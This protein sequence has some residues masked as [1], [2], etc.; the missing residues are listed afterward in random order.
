MGVSLTSFSNAT[1]M[2]AADVLGNVTTIRNWINGGSTGTDYIAVTS[3][4]MFRKLDVRP[5]GG[6]KVLKSMG[7]SGGYWGLYYNSDL[8]SRVAM[9]PDAHG[10]TAYSTVPQFGIRFN[11]PDDGYLDI[12]CSWWAWAIQSDQTVPETLNQ[13][14]FAVFLNS[15]IQYDTQRTL[16]DSA[17]DT[18]AFQGGQY[19]YAA[20]NFS[21]SART[22][23]NAGWN[24][25]RMTFNFA[26][27]ALASK[28]SYPLVWIGAR[29]MVVTY[30]RK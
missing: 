4:K 9:H 14:D 6:G 8:N 25:A 21:V 13:G 15:T 19:L 12:D 30:D 10:M 17:H 24:T 20:Q 7:P 23:V 27:R 28:A 11:C 29:S 16:Y 18:T 3:G 5:H 1:P 2:V 22:A 26:N